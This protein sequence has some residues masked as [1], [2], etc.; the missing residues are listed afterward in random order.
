MNFNYIIYV[1]YNFIFSNYFQIRNINFNYKM[2]NF[3]DMTTLE[4]LN[5]YV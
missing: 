2:A 4:T 5:N 1:G 3:I